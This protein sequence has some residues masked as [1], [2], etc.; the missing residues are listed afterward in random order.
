MEIFCI[1]DYKITFFLKVNTYLEG[2]HL[3][4]KNKIFCGFTYTKYNI[5]S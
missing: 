5:R 2:K 1:L 3:F 4:L